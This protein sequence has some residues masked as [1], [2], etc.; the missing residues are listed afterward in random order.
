MAEKVI[1]VSGLIK[2][3][4][5][6]RAVNNISFEVYAGEVFSLLGPN[7]A[8]KTTTVEILECLRTKTGGDVRVLGMDIDHRILEIKKRI[9]VLPQDFN[10]FDL[11]TVKEN[12]EYFGGMFPRQLPADELVH[13][14]DLDDK[15]DE[16][17]KN[18]SGGLKQR[19]G[20]A[21][22]MVNDPEIV[23][24]DEPT[25]GLDPKARRDVW[26]VIQGLK[27]RGKTVILTTHYMEEAEVLSDRVGIIDH[28]VFLALG[29]TRDIIDKHGQESKCIIYRCDET[30]ILALQKQWPSL[31][32]K[33]GDVVIRLENKNALAE[34]IYALDSSGGSYEQIQVTRPTLE[35]VFLGLTGKK[36]VSEEQAIQNKEKEARGLFGR[37]KKEKGAT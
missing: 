34:I 18:L 23:F 37:R 4:G 9:G 6:L 16:Y 31:E 35:D 12:I 27:D 30:C 7:G 29:T 5:T 17:F 10:A 13:L 11:L 28:G 1:E 26:G 3:Y 33:N 15:R 14:M 36:L 24:L 2:D 8:G 25:T 20:V 21:V 19:T 32:R 22:A